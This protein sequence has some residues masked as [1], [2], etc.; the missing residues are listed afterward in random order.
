MRSQRNELHIY[1]FTGCFPP[2]PRASSK[3]KYS[4]RKCISRTCDM[5]FRPHAHTFTHIRGGPDRQVSPT[6]QQRSCQRVTASFTTP[7]GY[8][9][10]PPYPR[11]PSNTVHRQR[12]TLLSTWRSSVPRDSRIMKLLQLALAATLL[13][14]ALAASSPPSGSI[15]VGPSGSGAKYTSLSSALADTSSN[16][17]FVY[18]GTYGGQHYIT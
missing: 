2:Q 9:T 7:S 16:V 17:Y 13:P 15:T 12:G 4:G 14:L 11:T 6:R 18:S 5:H 8:D 10:T 3:S 1:S